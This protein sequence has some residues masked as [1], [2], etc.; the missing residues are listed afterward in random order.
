M[1]VHV[2]AMLLRSTSDDKVLTYAARWSGA[3]DGTLKATIPKRDRVA[4]SMRADEEAE[5]MNSRCEGLRLALRAQEAH[6]EALEREL[7]TRPTVTQASF[8]RS[9]CF[10]YSAALKVSVLTEGQKLSWL[11]G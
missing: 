10:L 3:V 11:V 8:L 6:A 7:T 5:A 9:A 2:Q 4:V 1:P